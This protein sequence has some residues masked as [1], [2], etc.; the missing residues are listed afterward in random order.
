MAK[1]RLTPFGAE[2]KKRLIDMNMTQTEFCKKYN[3]PYTRFS[4]LITGRQ[5]NWKH[6]DTVCRALELDKEEIDKA[7]EG[8]A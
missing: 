8:I 7:A 6:I 1:M 5:P 4:E 2:V 3:I